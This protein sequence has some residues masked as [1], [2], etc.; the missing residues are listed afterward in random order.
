MSSVTQPTMPTA[1]RRGLRSLLL[2]ALVAAV[3]G[4]AGAAPFVWYRDLPKQEWTPPLGNAHIPDYT[5]GVGD[6]LSIRVYEQETLTT[7]A[8]VRNDGRLALTFIGEVTAAGKPPAALAREIEGR[9]KEFI[10]H[11]RVTVNVDQSQPI[12][13]S[14]VGEVTRGGSVALESPASLLQA[15]AVAGGPTEY[16]DKSRI[17]VIRRFPEFRRIRFT[18]DALLENKEGAAGFPL[19]TGDIVLVE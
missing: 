18:Y 19:R 15:M 12:A 16:A 4:C 14:M 10:V 8:K 13:V 3:G 2:F 17:F 1:H 7:T 9:L 5:V 6:T 11:P